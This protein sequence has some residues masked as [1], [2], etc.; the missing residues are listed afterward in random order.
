MSNK[1]AIIVKFFLERKEQSLPPISATGISSSLKKELDITFLEVGELL[2][3]LI[4]AD[5]VTEY[6]NETKYY[7]ISEKTYKEYLLNSISKNFQY[8]QSSHENLMKNI[9]IFNNL[10]DYSLETPLEYLIKMKSDICNDIYTI[11]TYKKT[12]TCK[13]F[14]HKKI[15][16]K[17]MERIWNYSELNIPIPEKLA[18]YINSTPL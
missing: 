8:L 3:P 13:S 16:C 2:Q 12:C 4:I 1:I 7:E 10:T 17:H 14:Y 5:I 11:D 18:E 15:P 6:Q 9:V